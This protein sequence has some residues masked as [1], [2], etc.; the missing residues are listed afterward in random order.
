TLCNH[1]DVELTQHHRAIY[2]AEATA[3]L[4]WK[5][6]NMLDEHEIVNHNELNDHMGE[7]DAY[8]HSRPF[9]ASLLV[10]NETGLKNLYKIVSHSH[11][12][13]F[14]RVP[15][16]PRSLLEKYREGILIGSGCNQGEV[17]ETLMQKSVDDAVKVADFYDFI[18][19]QPPE[20]Y[21]HLI[22]NELIQNEAQLYDI[23][24]NIVKLSESVDKKIVATGNVHYIDDHEKLY[25]QILIA[26]QKGN[27]LN[28]QALPDTPFRKTNEMLESFKFLGD[29]VAEEIVVKNSNQMND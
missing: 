29:K 25:R 20:N 17:F 24:R 16:V 11:I 10:Q 19:V 6:L 23:I 15:R 28:R 5:L 21:S 3:Y 4:F 26:S 2:D 14:Y 1:L 13:Y 9:H 8:Q 7:G 22:E 27:P 12:D 18:E